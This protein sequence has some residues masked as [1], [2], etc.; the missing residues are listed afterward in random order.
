M[1]GLGRAIPPTKRRSSFRTLWLSAQ[2][3]ARI[4]DRTIVCNTP[5]LPTESRV[6]GVGLIVLGPGQVPPGLLYR[7]IGLEITFYNSDEVSR[8][9]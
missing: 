4:D 6:V 1:I 8:G 7:P 5:S 3:P 2:V 9:M